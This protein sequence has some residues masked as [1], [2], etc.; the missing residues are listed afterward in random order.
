MAGSSVRPEAAAGTSPAAEPGLA[1]APLAI[2]LP[3][4][5][6]RVV[7]CSV[8]ALVLTGLF[9]LAASWPS[10]MGGDVASLSETA[11]RWAAAALR[12][13]GIAAY[14]VLV[15]IGALLPMHVRL[16]W[17]RRRNRTSGAGL[18]VVLSVLSASGLWLYYGPEGGRPAISALH[19]LIG[20]ALPVG[21]ILHRWLGRRS[22]VGR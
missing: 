1:P 5:Q 20:L 13:H 16:A 8:A 7:Y 12:L 17:L 21:L 6:R 18:I 11:R 10:V 9:W 4:W 22:R 2:A 14:V 19:W 15:A 3:R